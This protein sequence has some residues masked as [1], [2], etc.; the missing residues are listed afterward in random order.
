MGKKDTKKDKNGGVVLNQTTKFA[1]LDVP[2]IVQKIAVSANNSGSTTTPEAAA[3]TVPSTSKEGQQGRRAKA[4]SGPRM[5]S[6]TVKHIGGDSFVARTANPEWLKT[7]SSVYDAVKQ[8]RLDELSQKTPVDI[9]VTMPDGKVLEK[10]GDGHHFQAWK[11][12]PYDVAKA[13]SQGLADA[14]VV[15]RVTYQSYAP[16]YSP[17]EDGMD[18]VDTLME[19]MTDGGI[20]VDANGNGGESK[21]IVLL[22]DMNRPLVGTVAKLELL[23]FEDDRDAKTVFWHSSAHMLGEALEHLYGCKLTIGPPLAG[24]FY[25]DSYMGTDAFREEDCTTWCR[26]VVLSSVSSP[27]RCFPICQTYRWRRK[28]LRL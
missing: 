15:A 28:W 25:Y 24:G 14:A 7:R 6:E 21:S 12:T 2:G 26:Y 18:G 22:W 8:R 20:D 5:D 4:S 27:Q 23:K 10:D 19:A 11:T 9:T 1:V 16:D 13:I 17:A 3:E